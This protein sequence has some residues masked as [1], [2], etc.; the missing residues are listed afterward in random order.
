MV[1]GVDREGDFGFANLDLGCGGG[2]DGD[3]EGETISGWYGFE[4]SGGLGSERWG[5]GKGGLI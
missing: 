5:K 2:D 3:V 4:G 1:C